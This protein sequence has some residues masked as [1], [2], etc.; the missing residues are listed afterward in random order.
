MGS[1]VIRIP[2]EGPQVICVPCVAPP[3]V[4]AVVLC[5]TDWL[6][7]NVSISITS[8]YHCPCLCYQDCPMQ[9]LPL[10]PR[11]AW[12]LFVSTYLYWWPTSWRFSFAD[13]IYLSAG[14][15]LASGRPNSRP[16]AGAARGHRGGVIAGCGTSATVSCLLL[17]AACCC[18][19]ACLPRF[20]HTLLADA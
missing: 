15:W 4:K 8:R 10:M 5:W 13:R 3:K 6:A 1:Q 16:S 9:L 2:C 20:R 14:R 17:P 19:P 12:R 11:C 7:Q 18:W